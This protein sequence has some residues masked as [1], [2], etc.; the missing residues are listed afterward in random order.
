M[1]NSKVL[2]M[3]FFVSGLV[4][5]VI[6]GAILFM[7]AAMFA[8][9]GVDLGGNSSLLSEIRAPGGALLASGIVIMLGAFVAKIAF[10]SAVISILLYLSYGLSRMVSIAIDG[11]PA[12]GL[13]IAMVFEMVIGLA[14]VFAFLKYR[15]NF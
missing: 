15:E 9:N 4:L 14:C 7:P 1:K 5:I 13:V 2:K 8:L 12:E 11:M 3:I 6:G 10:T